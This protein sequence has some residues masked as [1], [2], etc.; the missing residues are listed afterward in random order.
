LSEDAVTVSLDVSDRISP[1][2][3]LSHRIG[4]LMHHRLTLPGVL[5]GILVLA[6]VAEGQPAGGF[7]KEDLQKALDRYIQNNPPDW[8]PLWDLIERRIII[9]EFRP[10]PDGAHIIRV[11]VTPVRNRP[12]RV[13]E[14]TELRTNVP[15]LVKT[16]LAQQERVFEQAEAQAFRMRGQVLVAIAGLKPSR[17]ELDEREQQ[18][19]KAEA[20][21]ARNEIAR[22]RQAAPQSGEGYCSLVVGPSTFPS[23]CGYY[24]EYVYTWVPRYPS[25]AAPA[26]P[27]SA[28]TRFFEEASRCQR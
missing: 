25:P 14:Q 13:E 9:E 20:A 7:K 17:P 26:P 27:V 22:A 23:A 3:V 5:C 1:V 28:I 2:L 24:G 6:A 21:R 10:A 4:I 11:L 12:L 19:R 18:R 15:I 8:R 16:A